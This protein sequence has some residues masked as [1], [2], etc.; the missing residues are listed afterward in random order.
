MRI[1]AS[2]RSRKNCASSGESCSIARARSSCLSLSNALRDER[3]SPRLATDET[4]ARGIGRADLKTARRPRSRAR[5]HSRR[6]RASSRW[7][8]ATRT[9]RSRSAPAIGWSGARATATRPACAEVGGTKDVDVDAVLALAPDLVIANQEE[10]ARGRAR[11]ARGARAGA[12]VAAAPRRRRHRAPRAARADPRRRASRR[13]T[14]V[15]RGYALP[16]AA[17]R[18]A[19]RAFVPIWMDP[20]MTLNADTFGSDVLAQRRRS[21]TCSAIGC[22]CTRSPPTSARARRATP[23]SRDV[24]YPRVTL[25]EVARARRR[26]DRAARRAARVHRRRRS[27]CSRGALPRARVVRVDRA[28]ICSGTARGRS[29]LDRARAE[30]RRAVGGIA[31]SHGSR[32]RRVAARPA[33]PAPL[34]HPPTA[35]APR[36]RSWSAVNTDAVRRRRRCAMRCHTAG[37]ARDARRLG[38]TCRRS[39]R[40]SASMMGAVGARS[41][42]PRGA[43]ARARARARRRRH[44]T[45]AC[46]RC[47]APVGFAEATAR[48]ALTLADLERRHVAG[49]GLAREGVGCAGCHALEPGGL[50]D[51]ASFVGGR[52]C[53]RDR[54]AY[55][56][57]PS[58][59]TTR[60]SQMIKTRAGAGPHVLES[61]LCASCHTVIVHRPTCGSG[62][63][64]RAGDVPR[65]ARVGASPRRACQTCHSRR[66]AAG[67]HDAV[68]DAPARRAGA[69]RLSPPHA[70]RRQR[71]PARI[72]SR[73]HADAGSAR[74][75]RPAELLARARCRDTAS[76]S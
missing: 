38:A 41:V 73:R 28:R 21:R 32:H 71:V 57:L 75:R 53:A 26:P 44:A 7:S 31:R 42:L 33:P 8:R 60:W 64:R 6:R 17:R 36:C 54:V 74:R 20:L 14:L 62:D 46:V 49:R 68:R 59:S 19:R 4:L 40:S 67:D 50:G 66:I 10:N 47:H 16:P 34:S 15:R 37:R 76:A 2:S 63:D 11:G 55:G 65:V 22:G 45:S 1:A 69:R 30:L 12:G 56:A 70:A 25:D 9:R 13:A 52:R 27:R 51:E 3:V 48:A 72:G 35:A 39:P 43:A 5:V 58:R 18:R 23:P 29:T 61:E 24:R